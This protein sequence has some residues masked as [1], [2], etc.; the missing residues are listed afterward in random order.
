MTADEQRAYSR[1]YAA[2]RKRADRD[3]DATLVR[4]ERE[5]FRREA[6]LAMASAMIIKGGWGYTKS[7]GSRH[8]YQSMEDYARAA[9][10][11]ADDLAGHTYFTGRRLAALK[12]RGESGQ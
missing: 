9:F 3:Q 8:N 5:A 11:F 1:G 4:E 12:A 2:G 10:Q 6:A 7:D